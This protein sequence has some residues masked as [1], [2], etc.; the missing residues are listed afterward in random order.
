MVSGDACGRP[1]TDFWRENVYEQTQK[2]VTDAFKGMEDA[3]TSFVST[4]KLDFAS[5]ADS[6]IADINR[7]II[8]QQITGPLADWL[9]GGLKTV[10]GSGGIDWGALFGGFLATGGTA[11]PGKMY[12]VNERGTEMLSMGGRDYLMMG[13][14]AGKVTPSHAL[15]GNSVVQNN[16][17]HIAGPS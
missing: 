14:Q 6:I 4:G 9:N 10:G 11:R 3:L 8:R 1:E 12:E 7:I 13:N 17:F 5:L 2:V 15:G 16:S